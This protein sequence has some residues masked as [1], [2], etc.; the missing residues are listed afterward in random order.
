MKNFVRLNKN[1]MKMIGGGVTPEEIGGGEL[2][3]CKAKCISGSVECEGTNCYA[4]DAVGK[5][6]GYCQAG[7][8]TRWC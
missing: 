6:E 8:K 7:G 3:T 1:E 5:V 4:T 2:A